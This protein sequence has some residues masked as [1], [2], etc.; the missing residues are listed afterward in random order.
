MEYSL[1]I[2][3][4]ATATPGYPLHLTSNLNKISGDYSPYVVYYFSGKNNVAQLEELAKRDT[5]VK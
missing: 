1:E 4:P 2:C 5:G 3:G